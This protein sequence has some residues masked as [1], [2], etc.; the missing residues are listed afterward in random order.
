MPL[1]IKFLHTFL[2]VALVKKTNC[3]Y[4]ECHTRIVL[5]P[6]KNNMCFACADSRMAVFFYLHNMQ[7]SV[8]QI[9]YLRLLPSYIL[10]PPKT[11]ANMCLALNSGQCTT[12]QCNEGFGWEPIGCLTQSSDFKHIFRHTVSSDKMS[13]ST[14]SCE[15]V[16]VTASW[17]AC[18]FLYLYPQDLRL[19]DFKNDVA[20]NRRKRL[21]F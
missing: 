9:I 13:G 11:S 6:W 1:G 14:L 19:W 16:P 7:K 8:N 5:V 17:A 3:N 2:H 12:W 15:N 20:G 4:H 18:Y 10:H 21:L